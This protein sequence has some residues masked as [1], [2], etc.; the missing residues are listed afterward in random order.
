MKI[1]TLVFIALLLAACGNNNSIQTYIEE[2]PS[3]RAL[4]ILAP[5]LYK[6]IIRQAENS[7]RAAWAEEGREFRVELSSYTPDEREQHLTRL[8]TMMMAGQ[9]YD[10]FFWDGHPVMLRSD[11]GHFADIYDLIDRNP[12]TS[13]ED[14]YTNVLEAWEF[15]GGLY[16]FPL[17]VELTYVGISTKL[18]QHIIDRFMQHSI[19]T[20]SELMQFYLE[21]RQ[22]YWDE[23]GHMGFGAG[24]H[25]L[26]E[27]NSHIDPNN[28]RADLNNAR[29]VEYLENMKRIYNVE[30]EEYEFFIE[31]HASRMED[32]AKRHVFREINEHWVSHVF[33]PPNPAFVHFRPLADEHGRAILRQSYFYYYHMGW[34]WSYWLAPVWGNISISTAGYADTAWEFTQYIITAL[35]EHRERH[36][37]LG[38]PHQYV[39]RFGHGAFV[40]PI[41][42]EYTEP[43]LRAFFYNRFEDMFVARRQER[44][45]YGIPTAPTEIYAA[46]GAAIA[47]LEAFNE[48]PMVLKPYL[49]ASLYQDAIDDFFLGV[50]SAW[51]AAEQINNRIGLWL[52]E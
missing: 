17:S 18:P 11:S 51:Q 25:L 3:Y 24:W 42:R 36:S 37:I 40:S 6:S 50:I 21:A 30:I 47:R 29:F 9:F 22:D 15:N 39:W 8:Q 13:R 27:I 44:S 49:P 2:N 48:M 45:F 35:V 20:T 10:M 7:M 12:N 23:I 19:I 26:S 34:G 46:Y 33:D 38:H 41:K 52:I 5:N 43:H 14:F 28:L 31:N 4:T 1:L 32:L 16:I